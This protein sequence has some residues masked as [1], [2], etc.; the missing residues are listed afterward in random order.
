METHETAIGHTRIV[1]DVGDG[2]RKEFPEVRRVY[3]E[4]KS[5][6][7]HR[8]ALERIGEDLDALK[9]EDHE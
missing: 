5:T 3:I 9:R 4:A 7:R 2:I 8:E 1:S 6:V